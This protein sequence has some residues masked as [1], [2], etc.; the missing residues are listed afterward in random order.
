MRILASAD[1]HNDR[2]NHWDEWHRVHS[3]MVETGREEQVDL[4]VSAGDIYDHASDPLEREAQAEFTTAMAEVCPVVFVK[5]NHDHTKDLDILRRLKTKHPVIVEEAAKVHYIAGAAIAAIAWPEASR[6]MAWAQSH[7]SADMDV[8]AAVQNVFRHLGDQLAEHDGPRLAL[9]HLM[10]DGAVTSTGQPLIGKPLNLGLSDLALLRAQWGVMGHIH[11]RQRWNVDGT[12]WDYTGSPL[13]DTFG[14]LEKKV[15][16]LG[17]FDATGLREV[18]ELETPAAPMLQPTAEWGFSADGQPGWSQLDDVGSV[19]RAHIRL[20]YR[21]P[22]DQRQAAQEAAALLERK[23]LD[24]G[25]AL[26]KVVPEV[27]AETRSRMPEVAR[28]AEPAE[29]LIA[30]WEAIGFDPGERKEPLVGKFE[31]LREEVHQDDAA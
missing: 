18:R 5:G 3:W 23:W 28:A 9:G 11:K 19:E 22:K 25:A 14:Q 30:Y 15:V 16:L 17:E 10:V 20:T 6:I 29:Q 1:H 27:I 4:F 8:R 13:R 2:Q 21:V 7:E 26:V 12:P 24:S 31:Q